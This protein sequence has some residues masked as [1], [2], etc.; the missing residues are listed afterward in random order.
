[1]L[2][3]NIHTTSITK[4]EN[5]IFQKCLILYL[6]PFAYVKS[7]INVSVSSVEYREESYSVHGYYNTHD[8]DDDDAVLPFLNMH[9]Q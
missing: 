1:M 4:V 6:L 2:Q 3:N 5:L 8:D 9:Q 7:I